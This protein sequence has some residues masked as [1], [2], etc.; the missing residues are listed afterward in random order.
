[1]V[2]LAMCPG[3][4]RTSRPLALSQLQPDVDERL[5]AAGKRTRYRNIRTSQAWKD[6]REEFQRPFE[7]SSHEGATSAESET[8]AFEKRHRDQEVAVQDQTQVDRL[9]RDALR[10]RRRPQRRRRGI[11]RS[12]RRCQSPTDKGPLDP[13]DGQVDKTA[14]AQSRITFRSRC[15][16]SSEHGIGTRR[17]RQTRRKPFRPKQQPAAHDP[18]THLPTHPQNLTPRIPHR[19]PDTDPPH[20]DRVSRRQQ[21]RESLVLSHGYTIRGSRLS[22]AKHA[23]EASL[24]VEVGGADGFWRGRGERFSRLPSV[25]YIVQFRPGRGAQTIDSVAQDRPIQLQP[26]T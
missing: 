22:D 12:N 18:P 25:P 7:P 3:Y 13:I 8:Q 21:R 5:Q 15:K 20:H 4:G 16:Q 17:T 6:G 19:A 14:H 9:G 2:P 26:L 1:M 23:A 11:S 24:I 10:R